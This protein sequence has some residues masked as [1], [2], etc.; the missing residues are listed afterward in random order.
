MPLAF[1]VEYDEL[2][3]DEQKTYDMVNLRITDGEPYEIDDLPTNVNELIV[4]HIDNYN[5][6]DT[7]ENGVKMMWI[8]KNNSEVFPDTL[9]TNIVLPGVRGNEYEKKYDED[10]MLSIDYRYWVKT[11]V[12]LLTI[13][14]K[15]STQYCEYNREIQY[16][17]EKIVLPRLL[18][19]LKQ[20]IIGNY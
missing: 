19:C 14:D 10:K 5:E 1:G 15:Y 9:M 4:G 12:T 16:L 7:N 17:D 6:N 3:L 20:K 2:S 8:T 11:D 13:E 18:E